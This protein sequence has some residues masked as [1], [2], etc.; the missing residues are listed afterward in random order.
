L[1][2]CTYYALLK[3]RH[4]TVRIN[5]LRSARK[6]YIS[7]SSTGS[8]RV[9]HKHATHHDTTQSPDSYELPFQHHVALIF[10]K[11][12]MTLILKIKI[13]NAM[14]L[15]LKMKISFLVHFAVYVFVYPF[16]VI[17][18][19]RYKPEGREFDPIK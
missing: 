6:Q 19:L 17:K 9:G 12:F 5:L 18:E 16:E 11:E 10:H 2:L 7:T 15:F 4:L 14:P 13:F 8:Q 1:Y 3:P